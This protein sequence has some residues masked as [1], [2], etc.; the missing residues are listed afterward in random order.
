MTEHV[1]FDPRTV[2]K[3]VLSETKGWFEKAV[4]DPQT[5]NFTTQL[6]VHFEE[7]AEMITELTPENDEVGQAIL[8]ALTANKHLGE[9]LKRSGGVH[10]KDE[11]RRLFLD[12]ICDQLVTGTGTAHMLGMDPVGGLNEVNRGNFSKF[13]ENGEPIFDENMKVTKGPN[14]VK[15]DLTP[16]V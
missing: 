15:P 6:G 3:P 5:K 13:D 4:P 8:D 7:V 10:V 2:C 14:Y 16:F 12:A 9:L 11:N 1:K